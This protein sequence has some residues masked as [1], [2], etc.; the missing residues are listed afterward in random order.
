M[1]Q[2]DG[3][4]LR[5][6]REL[7]TTDPKQTKPFQRAGG[8]RG[9]AIKPI[10]NVM[11]LT[12]HFGPMGIG[13]GTEEPKFNVIDNREGEILVYCILSCWYKE[14][15][16]ADKAIIWGIGGD[17]VSQKRSGLMFADDEAF[18]KAYTDA[19]TNAFMRIGVSAD[20]YMG[21]FEDS[22]YLSEVR[23]H[24]DNNRAIQQQLQSPK[25]A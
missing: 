1:V 16:D 22:K 4:N 25:T 5:H 8:F 3:N 9:T 21:L 24:Y 2:D 12:E 7:S 10:W 18:K 14:S 13:W 6:W 11:R 15:P 19:L 17:K 23:E 20:V